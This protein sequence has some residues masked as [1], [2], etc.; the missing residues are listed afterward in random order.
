M[1]ASK[2]KG[3]PATAPT[4]PKR[5][6]EPIDIRWWLARTPGQYRDPHDL[7][8][9]WIDLQ[10][11]SISRRREEAKRNARL[12]GADV[13]PFGGIA[14]P[15]DDESPRQNILLNAADTISSKWANQKVIP[16]AVT[17]GGTHDE[18]SR[19][20][21]FN[22]GIEALFE[23][24]GVFAN[25]NL[26]CD[27]AL[28]W[29]AGVAK[30]TSRFGEPVVDRVFAWELV[31]DP[32]EARYGWKGVRS[33]FHLHVM[34]KLVLLEEY[35]DAI[36]EVTREKIL[37][38]SVN[39]QDSSLFSV[40]RKTDLII[41]AEGWHLPS[42]PGA[43]DGKYF[44][45]GRG[46]TAVFDD[47][48]RN[49]FPL[50]F[51]Y[52]KKPRIGVW[53]QPMVTRQAPAQF[54]H[55]KLTRKI[56]DSHDL[57]AVARII[58]RKGAVV[59][60]HLDDEVGTVLE[61][62]GDPSQVREWTPVAV[63]SDTYSYHESQASNV[64]RFE[65]VSEMASRGQVP[66][67]LQ[68]AS[69]KALQVY[70]D[71]GDGRLVPSFR[72]REEFLVTIGDLILDALREDGSDYVVQIVDGKR[73]RLVRFADLDIGKDKYRLRVQATSFLAHTPS[74]KYQQLSEMRERGDITAI[75]FRKMSGIPDILAQNELD[76]S[77]LDICDKNI[78]AILRD[79]KALTVLPVDNHELVFERGL[80]AYHLARLRDEDPAKLGLL[81]DYLLQAQDFIKKKNAAAAPPPAPPIPMGAPPPGAPPPMPGPPAPPAPMPGSDQAVPPEAA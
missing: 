76:T 23:Q 27:D 68:N 70:T 7:A 10:H 81:L 58:A 71:E 73:M 46:W 16:M 79:G 1:A 53:Q 26:W 30:V 64:L 63:G 19:A 47:Y 56:G 20:E 32:Q 49:R 21:E 77:S 29:E 22:R 67:G 50:A 4:P 18:Q 40:D 65:G 38:A 52:Q 37:N 3:K 45:G 36:D 72:N 51:L 35:G 17:E 14:A 28:T 61:V 44:V 33:M 12:M 34:D 75:E 2:A 78:A 55:D 41:V 25:D 66:S 39:R 74:A 54:A 8:F 62:D 48:K 31:V 5:G 6:V 57:V 60:S 11:S 15:T 42:G 59:K 43:G 80:K 13:T 24:L 9:A 69:G